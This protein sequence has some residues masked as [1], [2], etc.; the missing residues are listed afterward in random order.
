MRGK[1]KKKVFSYGESESGAQQM[2]KDTH[3]QGKRR[4]KNS[5]PN[6]LKVIIHRSVSLNADNNRHVL[7]SLVNLIARSQGGRECACERERER[8]EDG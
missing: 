7:C 4:E 8:E 6:G 1:K 2:C 5:Q 3:E